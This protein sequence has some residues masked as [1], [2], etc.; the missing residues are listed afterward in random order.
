MQTVTSNIRDVGMSLV[1]GIATLL[2]A[3]APLRDVN[4][5]SS[6]IVL[7][8]PSHAFAEL[9]LEKRRL[10]SRLS[11][12]HRHFIAVARALLRMQPDAVQRRI[13]QH[14]DTIR[15]VI[16]QTNLV[17]HSTTGK[18]MVAVKEAVD[19][20][21]DAISCLHDPAEGSVVLIPDTNAMIISPA[22][23]T[24]SFDGLSE[25]EILLVPTLLSELDSLKTEHRNPDVRQKAQ[26]VIRQIKEYRRRG[27]LSDGVV[28]VENQIRLCSFA[29]EPR[30]DEILP[31]LNADSP[32]DRMLASCV[33]AMRIHPRSMVALVTADINLQNKA[34]F[35]RVPFIEPPS[36]E[37]TAVDR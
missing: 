29:V 17:W 10:Q 2:G 27:S 12:D 11:D 37:E 6:G 15:E 20:I 16:E 33:E 8:G 5:S 31:W 25:F 36:C 21:L 32:D 7:L 24:W 3:S 14:D 30:V 35:A 28:I 19:G 13:D 34:E 18:A 9:S 1:D 26:S 4:E 23:Q 22:F